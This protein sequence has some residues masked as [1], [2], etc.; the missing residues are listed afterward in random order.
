MFTQNV[1]GGFVVGW[2]LL[3]FFFGHWKELGLF[4][5]YFY[6]VNCMPDFE[7]NRWF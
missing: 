2:F 4:C 5:P 7:E 6:T 1:T 3:V